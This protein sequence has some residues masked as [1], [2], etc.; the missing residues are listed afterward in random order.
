MSDLPDRRLNAYRPDLAEERLRGVVEAANYVT[1]TTCVVCIPVVQLRSRPELECGTDTELLLGET[2]RVL[3]SGGGW[4][5][6]K[7][8]FDDYVGYV[9]DYAFT[10]V[11]RSLTHIITAP[12]T[13]VYSGPDLRLPTVQA[14]SMGNRIKVVDQRDM[15]GTRYFL[16]E[17]GEA[18]IANHCAE[19]SL[20]LGGDYVSIA[21]RFLETPYLWGGRSGFG[22][23]CSGLVQLSMMMTGRTAPRDTDMQ[24]TG[25]GTPIDRSELRRGD[26]V[27]WNGHVA[28]MEDEK[29]LLHANGH[30]MTVSHEGLNEAIDRIGWLY[31]QPTG[32]RRP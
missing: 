1:G 12:R 3:D 22:I 19:A 14:L 16:L 4:A 8:D 11:V 20:P 25:L 15:R 9:P 21:S 18:V 17:G 31:D 2:V 26:L 29:T 32:Y 6:V 28:I 30:T 24:A 23:D 13:F 27:F 10:P 5:W 7:A